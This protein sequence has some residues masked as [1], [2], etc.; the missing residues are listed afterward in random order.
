MAAYP[1]G[2]R[3]LPRRQRLVLLAY[4]ALLAFVMPFICWAAWADPAHPHGSP[5]FVF[6]APPGPGET[7]DKIVWSLQSYCGSPRADIPPEDEAGGTLMAGQSLPDATL[8]ITAL[9]MLF[10]G[11]LLL[12]R[13]RPSTERASRLCVSTPFTPIVPTPPP[14]AGCC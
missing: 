9:L 10:A 7:L 6:V 12:E 8:V 5:H 11:W 2:R 14:R 1:T 4:V 13:L 3:Q